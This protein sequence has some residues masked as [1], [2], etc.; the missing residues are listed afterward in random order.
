MS[1]HIVV[2]SAIFPFSKVCGLARLQTAKVTFKVTDGHW[3]CIYSINHIQF[4]VSLSLQLCVYVAPFAKY[5]HLFHS[6]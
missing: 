6:I 1:K 4:P 3:H 5:Y 2:N